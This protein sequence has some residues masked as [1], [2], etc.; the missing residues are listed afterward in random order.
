VT[1]ALVV[2]SFDP[3][4]Q[5]Q[6]DLIRRVAEIAEHV[7]VAVEATP[8]HKPLYTLEERISRVQEAVAAQ[9]TVEVRAYDGDLAR[10]VEETGATAYV[11]ALR[12]AGDV[13]RVLAEIQPACNALGLEI[14]SLLAE[15]KYGFVTTALV[16]DVVRMGGDSRPFVP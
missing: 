14:I 16:R 7:I 9:S 13:E 8:A 3:L 4:I 2:G 5:G 12:S 10:L 1:I 15:P 6:A 11:V